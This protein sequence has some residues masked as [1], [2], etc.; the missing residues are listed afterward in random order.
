MSRKR[1]ALVLLVPLLLGALTNCGKGEKEKGREATPLDKL[2]EMGER[3]DAGAA[4][5]L[6][7][8]DPGTA[9]RPWMA[10]PNMD[11]AR[12]AGL[13]DQLKAAGVTSLANLGFEY[14]LY[15]MSGGRAIYYLR[16]FVHTGEDGVSFLNFDGRADTSGPSGVKVESLSGQAQPLRD[17]AQALLEK[18]KGPDC[19]KL[20]F[21]PAETLS[22]LIT[23]EGPRGELTQ[24]MEKSKAGLAA[25]CSTLAGLKYDEVRVHIDDQAFLARGA[26]GSKGVVRGEFELAPEAVGY[27]LGDFRPF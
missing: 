24:R 15:F 11:A 8:A 9:F 2:A 4:E 7:G 16:T 3:L 19:T 22:K 23:A 18:V 12:A 26:E 6:K 20:P 27:A 17:A 5:F 13:R 10:P 25:T 1:I 21:A 14:E